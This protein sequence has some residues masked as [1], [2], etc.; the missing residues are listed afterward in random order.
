[1]DISKEIEKRQVEIESVINNYMP[2]EEGLQKTIFSGM[3]Y[4]INAGG[5]RIRP[6]LMQETYKLFSGSGRIIEPFMASL[7]MIH[8]YSL[9]HDDMPCVDNDDMRRGKPT[10]HVAYGETMALFVGDGLLN[11]AF[12]TI[13]SGMD[14]I[15]V[16]NPSEVMAYK[17]ASQYISK[18]A[19]SFGMLAGQ[20]VDK[21]SEDKKNISLDTIM[22]LYDKKTAELLKAAMV[23][24][25]ILANASDKEIDIIERVAYNTGIAFQIQDDILDIT[26]SEEELGKPI[27][28]DERNNKSTYVAYKGLEE[29]EKEVKR[30]TREALSLLSQLNKKNEFLEKLLEY[31]IHRT[32]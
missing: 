12:E 16:N 9:V 1:M 15:D 27:G 28:S 10:T 22:Y 13:A 21:E 23:V 31:M 30:L 29:S 24:G 3:N 20:V 6:M 17:K 2:K 19:G 11:L 25:A 8:T 18:C 14:Y 7:E 32:K 5:K 26:S 4:S